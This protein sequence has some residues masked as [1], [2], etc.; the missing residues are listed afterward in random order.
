MDM[1][2]NLSGRSVLVSLWARQVTC[3]VWVAAKERILGFYSTG[4]KI[5]ENDL[6]V[7]TGDT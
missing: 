6:Q 5:K 4:P 7:T 1:L 3:V 2:E